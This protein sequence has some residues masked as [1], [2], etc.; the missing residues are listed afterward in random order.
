MGTISG[1]LC[2]TRRIP[3]KGTN[4]M[5]DNVLGGYEF[6]LSERAGDV[7]LLTLN[8]PDRLNAVH[9]PMQVELERV[10]RDADRDRGSKAIVLTG[11]GRAFCAGG[12]VQTMEK[13]PDWDEG[14]DTH[15]AQ[16]HSRARNLVYAMLDMEKPLVAMVNGAAVGLGATLALLADV[17]V[18][19]NRARIGDRHVSVGLVAGDGAQMI[20]PM[21]IGMNRAKEFLM[22]GDLVE[23]ENLVRTGL[24]NHLVPEDELRTFTLS[25][26]ERLAAQPAYACR[27]TKQ[28]LNAQ[29]RHQASISLDLGLAWEHLAE[30]MP[31]HVEAAR[32]WTEGRSRR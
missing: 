28:L 4:T 22:T 27:A 19:S 26:A 18:A 14:T 24:V 10:F 9:G 20:W 1:I 32:A 30:Q 3:R 8:R 5:A 11:A 17:V 13:G 23:G 12:D 31:E 15:S 29:I 16:I 7:L 2:H 6:I 21:L 25:L